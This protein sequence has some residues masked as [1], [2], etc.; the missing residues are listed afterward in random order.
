MKLNRDSIPF[1][2]HQRTDYADA[3]AASYAADMEALY[4]NIEPWLPASLENAMDIGCGMAGIDLLISKA[5]PDARFALVD[6]EGNRGPKTGYHGSAASFGCY[7]SF[8]AVRG[9]MD[10]N[11][12]DPSRFDMVDARGGLPEGEFDLVMSFLSWGFHYPVETY[13]DRIKLSNGGVLIIDIR[14]DTDGMR[15]LAR[16]FHEMTKIH[17]GAKHMRVACR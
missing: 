15:A 9:F 11:D 3:I 14:N 12:A 1:L 5:Y 10:E 8:D 17:S 13:L 2:I 6:L 16:R 4:K 7:H